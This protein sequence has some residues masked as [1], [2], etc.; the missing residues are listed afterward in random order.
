MKNINLCLVIVFV[1]RE[2]A[3]SGCLRHKLDEIDKH[4]NEKG[5][6]KNRPKDYLSIH[7]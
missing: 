7:I 6:T 3:A 2:A 1:W 5:T 4:K